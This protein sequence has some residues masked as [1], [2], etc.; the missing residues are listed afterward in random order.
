MLKAFYQCIFYNGLEVRNRT[1][2]TVNTRISTRKMCHLTTSSVEALMFEQ[3]PQEGDDTLRAVLI[4]IRQ[5]DFITEQYQPFA[6]L[7]KLKD[8]LV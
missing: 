5:V 2:D 1:Q 6:K 3:L 8:C 4:H 7:E